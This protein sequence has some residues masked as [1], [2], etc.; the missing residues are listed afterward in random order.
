MKPVR[1]KRL[2]AA[3]LLLLPSAPLRGQTTI[4]AF[5]P[6]VDS[7]FRLSSKVR[8]VF[9]AKGYMEDGDLDH[10][11]IGPS[12]QFN[13]R[14]FEKL[15]EIT[16]FDL[17]DMKR[18]PVV[19]TTGYRYLPSRV[20]PTVNRFQSIIELHIPFPGRTLITDRNRFDL[21]WLTPGFQWTYRNRVTLERRLA[22]RSYHPAPY[23]AAEFGY[24]SQVSKWDTTRLF[25]G[26]LLPVTAHVQLDIYYEHV[27]NTQG[28]SNLQV[29]A[30]GLIVNFY[31]PRYKN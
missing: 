15:K 11:Q 29:N 6:E 9:N 20:Q 26:C 3:F 27:N 2:I 19:F 31:F 28:R 14:P 25:A 10:A 1:N 4:T 16:V 18:M 21:D 8:L 22:V 5:L 23:G 13:L 24:Q 17:D 7:Y 12:L 30:A